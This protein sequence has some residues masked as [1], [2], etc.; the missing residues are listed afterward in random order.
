MEQSQPHDH[1][2]L[3]T[4]QTTTKNVEEVVGAPGD[5]KELPTSPPLRSANLMQ[6]PTILPQAEGILMSRLV[7]D[8][9]RMVLPIGRGPHGYVYEV[10]N[11]FLKERFALEALSLLDASSQKVEDFH[12]LIVLSSLLKEDDPLR[13][14]DSGIARIWPGAAAEYIY[15]IR[16]LEWALHTVSHGNSIQTDT[17]HHLAAPRFIILQTIGNLLH[18]RVYEVQDRV[19]RKTLIVVVPYLSADQRQLQFSLQNETALQHEGI[20][21]LIEWQPFHDQ[22]K[23]L[24]QSIFYLLNL[25]ECQTLTE[26]IRNHPHPDCRTAVRLIAP[27]C[28]AVASAHEK[29]CTYASLETKNIVLHRPEGEED[30]KAQLAQIAIRARVLSTE[31]GGSRNTDQ[32]RPS[33]AERIRDVFHLGCILHELLTG[34]H[35]I[36]ALNGVDLEIYHL[37]GAIRKLRHVAPERD[38]PDILERV[39]G[40]MLTRDA[41]QAYTDCQTLVEDLQLFLDKRY[42]LISARTFPR[43][44]I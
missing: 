36:R 32:N 27:I 19:L 13:V 20:L 3:E 29:G 14:V 44:I 12:R 21:R 8:R 7:A 35:P 28:A 39:V 30:F 18:G 6:P 5:K 41:A 9:Y 33:K 38:F 22:R 42:N 31:P 2:A 15:C 24:A 23:W 1:S 25:P 4:A 43:K 17:L 11:I 37:T 16:A 26:F 34:H 40:K 10:E